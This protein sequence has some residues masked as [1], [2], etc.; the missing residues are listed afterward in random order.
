MEDFCIYEQSLALRDL[1]FDPEDY[2]LVI[3][4]SNNPSNDFI[5]LQ[6]DW[7][8]CPLKSQAFRWFR[9]VHGL[10]H[11][12]PRE[13]CDGEMIGFDAQVESD[14]G[15]ECDNA[16]DTPEEAENACLDKMI[17]IVKEK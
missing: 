6:G 10:Y 4:P 16:Y 3:D 5:L 17:E 8:P 11:C 9:E 15:T 12:I 2:F 1:G 7:I 14:E 13:W